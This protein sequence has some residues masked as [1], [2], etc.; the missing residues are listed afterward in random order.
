M[1]YL[2]PVL[3]QG[4]LRN[5]SHSTDV[6]FSVGIDRDGALEVVIERL[7]HSRDAFELHDNGMPGER[8]NF[9]RLEGDS[10][11]GWSIQSDHFI[12]SK[13]GYDAREGREI[14]IQGHCAVAELRR[15]IEAPVATSRRVW[16]VRQLRAAH[17]MT[18]SG[19]VGEVVV[20]GPCDIATT[21]QQPS[22]Q[23]QLTHPTVDAGDDWW[24]ESERFMNH[25]ARVLSFGC[26]CYLVPVMEQ[27]V[28]HD[29]LVW[30]VVRRDRVEP[31]FLPPFHALFMESIFQRACESFVTNYSEVEAL[32]PA[33]RWLTAPVALKEQRLINA[34]TALECII[35]RTAPS[36]TRMFM[37]RKDF[38]KLSREV[39]AVL[40]SSGAPPGMLAKILDLNR[41]TI[42]EQINALI[43]HRG[44]FV[45]DF[46]S[47]WIEEVVRVRNQLI[48]TGVAPVTETES[49]VSFEHI[50][51][52]REIVTR[53]I[54]ERI[55]F[56]G[57]YFSWLHHHRALH[58]PTCDRME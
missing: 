56:V 40:E 18:W 14:E 39:K 26:A 10:D 23:I 3:F 35:D 57:P 41:R 22:G 45:E 9:L 19:Q 6:N 52:A 47:N 13:F 21:S 50:V 49:S 33:I 58:F 5:R 51:W 38:K 15:S 16:F 42:N 24:S 7:P 1:S 4:R 11:S 27:R 34:M 29:H 55:G 36:G 46:P 31:P 2:E 43:S 12:I 32:D 25:V 44:I 37:Q 8:V 30:R 48:H 53:L 17:A 28:Y 20:A 54:L